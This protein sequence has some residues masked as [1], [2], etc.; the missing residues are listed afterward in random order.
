MDNQ[1]KK[2]FQLYSHQAETVEFLSKT[3]RAFITSD[4][5]TGKTF[6]TTEAYSRNKTG[7]MLVLCPKSIMQASWGA[8]IKKFNSELTYSIY[9]IKNKELAFLTGSDIVIMN[10]DAVKWL[11]KNTHLLSKFDWLVIDEF[12]AFKHRTSQR[13]KAVAK[14][15]TYFNRRVLLSGTPNTNSVTELWH[16]TLILDEGERLGKNFFAFR[17]SVCA[18][19]QVGPSA[20]MVKWEDKP[21]SI[22]AVGDILRDITIRHELEEVLDMP[23]H[24]VRTLEV[25]L[26]PK[27]LK[28]YNTLKAESILELEQGD[29]NAVNAA[30]RANKLMQ[31]CSG[32][33]YNEEGSYTPIHTERY[34]LVM[35]LVMERQHSVVIVNWRHQTEELINLATKAGI[36][37]GRIDGSVS[38]ENRT[39]HIEDYQAG[40][41]KVMFLHPS[42]G[43]HGVTLTKG[44][45]TIW[46][47]PTYNLEHF[48]QANHRIYRAG[49]TK[50]TETILIAAK[51]TLEPQVYKALNTKEISMSNMLNYLKT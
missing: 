21:G 3:P 28:Q 17:N 45:T 5:G 9:N 25:E 31:M 19:R 46:A 39:K 43:A 6:A 42:S 1:G 10:H 7:R 40:K 15:T 47:S 33:V 20:Q 8:D 50:R 2:E 16:P 49:Q 30:V 24:I 14:L 37:Y 18:A 48:T 27:H 12:T 32:A 51:D 26:S 13:S 22:E 23:E 44:T 4:P 35:D 41:L 11:V 36:A 29:I 34:E 38:L